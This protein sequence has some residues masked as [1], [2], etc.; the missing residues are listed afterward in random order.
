MVPECLLQFLRF[1]IL[2]PPAPAPLARH[3]LQD[4]CAQ[5][6]RELKPLQRLQHT[7]AYVS[8]RAD[9]AHA[10]AAPTAAAYVSIRQHTSAFAQLLRAEAAPKA[11]AY[12]SSAS[13]YVLLYQ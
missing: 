6:L 13:V 1:I 7:S 4:A 3:Y 9:P 2:T 10:E 5:L 12:A 11:A 8:I